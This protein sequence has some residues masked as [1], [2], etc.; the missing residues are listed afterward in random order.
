MFSYSL[1]QTNYL[2]SFWIDFISLIIDV[3]LFFNYK[4]FLKKQISITSKKTSKPLRDEYPNVNIHRM[5]IVFWIRGFVLVFSRIWDWDWNPV[6]S[7]SPV[8]VPSSNFFGTVSRKSV[9]QFNIFGTLTYLLSQKPNYF[10]ICRNFF[11]DKLQKILI[12]FQN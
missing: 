11:R 1:I 8:S 5:L 6:L 7:P 12:Y 4:K 2:N 10:G 3:K 9:P